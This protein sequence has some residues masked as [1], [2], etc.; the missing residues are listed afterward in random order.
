MHYAPNI[1]IHPLQRCTRKTTKISPFEAHFDR[2]PK[3]TLTV[4]CTKPKLSTLSYENI[5]NDYLDED[6]VTTEAIQTDDK[7][8]NG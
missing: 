7:W 2:K 5:I 1:I 8:Q 4:I 6:T 3:T